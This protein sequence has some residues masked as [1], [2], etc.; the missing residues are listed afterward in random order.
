MDKTG[1]MRAIFL[2]VKWNSLQHEF[3]LVSGFTK[4]EK[5]EKYILEEYKDDDPV[6]IVKEYRRL[7]KDIWNEPDEV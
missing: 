4:Y 7:V 3:R 6:Q 2:V 1:Q 5:A